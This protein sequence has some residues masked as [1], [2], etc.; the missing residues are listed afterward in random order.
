M[1]GTKKEGQQQIIIRK[2]IIKNKIAKIEEEY[3]EY[4]E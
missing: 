4:N 1:S 3:M 2:I